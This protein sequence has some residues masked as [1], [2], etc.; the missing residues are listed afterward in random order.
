MFIRLLAAFQRSQAQLWFEAVWQGA[1]LGVLGW[2]FF[3]GLSYVLQRS[4][5][6]RHKRRVFAHRLRLE[7]K[8][9]EEIIRKSQSE[10]SQV[11]AELD[12]AENLFLLSQAVFSKTAIRPVLT[13]FEKVR[14]YSESS[15]TDRQQT[16]ESVSSRQTDIVSAPRWTRE[17]HNK[18]IEAAELALRALKKY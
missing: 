9:L 12:R 8:T 13:F 14:Q 1:L 17:D 5:T 2:A 11:L 6:E 10:P 7:V 16:K 18:L 3:I 15:T 4:A